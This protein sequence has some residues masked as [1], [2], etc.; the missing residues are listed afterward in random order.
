MLSTW[1]LILASKVT[2]CV[3]ISLA[4]VPV[5]ITSSAVAI[6]ICAITAEIK[7]Y[8]SIINKKKKEHDK[9]ALLGKDKSNTTEVL[10]ELFQIKF[11]KIELMT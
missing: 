11:S 2:G 10:K 3:S 4:C 9:I 7:K 5:S 8:K 1:G 6:K